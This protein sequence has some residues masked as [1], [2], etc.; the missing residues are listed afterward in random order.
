M[1]TKPVAVAVRADLPAALF[2][3]AAGAISHGVPDV[4][5]SA[6]GSVSGHPINLIQD[7]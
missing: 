3:P 7:A 1:R 2:P 4:D 6:S 5:R